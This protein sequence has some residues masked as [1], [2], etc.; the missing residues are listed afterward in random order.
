MV[1]SRSQ[2]RDDYGKPLEVYTTVCVMRGNVQLI[3]GTEMIKAGINLS[4][5]VISVMTR[6]DSRLK[7]EHFLE[8]S[9][10]IYSVGAIKPY[11]DKNGRQIGLLITAMRDV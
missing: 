10:E 3:N 11:L 5:E 4:S 7:H 1:K 2:S 9:G 6:T 8:W